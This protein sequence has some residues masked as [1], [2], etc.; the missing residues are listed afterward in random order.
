MLYFPYMKSKIFAFLLPA[1]CGAALAVTLSVAAAE[2]PAT[3][4]LTTP[5]GATR[6]A[7]TTS[8]VPTA[9]WNT[10]TTNGTSRS[11]FPTTGRSARTT[12]RGGVTV[13]FSDASGAYQ[14]EVSAWPY[15]DLDVAL[16]EEA[17]AGNAA[18]EPDTL[19]IVRAYR[20]DMFEMT[21][22][23]N[24]VGYVVQSLPENATSTIN[25]LKSWHFI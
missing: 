7:L 1:V 6:P 12:E 24:G 2:N 17:P 25:I 5:S 11:L 13:Q 21:F 4:P 20:D 15:Q 16:G 8:N 9:I 23:K 10:A 14:F 18:D 22:V 19:G 3:P